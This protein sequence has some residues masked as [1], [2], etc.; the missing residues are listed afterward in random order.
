MY[1]GCSKVRPGL[2]EFGQALRAFEGAGKG[3]RNTAGIAAP[4]AREQ[5]GPT[6][7]GNAKLI[8]NRF[9]FRVRAR[10]GLPMAIC[11]FVRHTSGKRGWRTVLT[12]IVALGA[13]FFASQGAAGQQ[14]APSK[15][16]AHPVSKAPSPFADVEA[17]LQQGKFE[18]AKSRIQEEL[19]QNPSRPEGYGLLGLVYAAEKNY[20]EALSAFQQGLKL[21]PK[22]T[23]IRID[24]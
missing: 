21:N 19:Q 18:D 22:S 3:Q 9:Q 12:S 7:S 8:I 16:S 5:V 6:D 1:Q 13:I 11:S 10:G 17:L 4:A 23:G 14:A 20:T 15:Q 24:M 2:S